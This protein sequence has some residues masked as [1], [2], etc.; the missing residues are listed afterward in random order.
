ML[1]GSLLVGGITQRAALAALTL[2][3]IPAE[4]KIMIDTFGDQHRQFQQRVP[5]VIP[6][7][8]WPIR[9]R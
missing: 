7:I 3:N 8:G 1:F 9:T 2:S 4:E 6:G 5:Q